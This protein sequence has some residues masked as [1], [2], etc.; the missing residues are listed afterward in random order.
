MS[1]HTASVHSGFG[2]YG[3]YEP[4]V[5][6]RIV[7]ERLLALFD[8]IVDKNRLCLDRAREMKMEKIMSRVLAVKKRT[9]SIRAMMESSHWQGRYSIE[10]ISHKDG[11]AMSDA[12][13][14]IEEQ[15][16]ACGSVVGD[17]TCMETDLHID[18]RFARM[19][20]H[21]RKI[22]SLFRKRTRLFKKMRV[23]G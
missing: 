3:G 9:E 5:A 20:D 13:R 2:G 12:D 15:I 18:E 21:L 17:M 7:R 23:Y 14:E 16:A 19:N 22:E 11:T 6:E 1:E 10:R 4:E 8:A